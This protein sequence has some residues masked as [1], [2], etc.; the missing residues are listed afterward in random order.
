MGTKNSDRSDLILLI[1]S[2]QLYRASIMCIANQKLLFQRRSRPS[3]PGNLHKH[4]VKAHPDKLTEEEEK[5]DKF[6]WTWDYFI[7]KDDT[8]AT[9]V[10]CEV[11]ISYSRTN[12]LKRHLKRIHK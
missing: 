4:L 7:L 12:Y 3:N 8:E 11:I 1:W 6:H 2:S 5:E 10:I 9:C